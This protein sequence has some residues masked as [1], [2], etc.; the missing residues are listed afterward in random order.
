MSS[1][2]KFY[3]PYKYTDHQEGACK[4]F[5]PAGP[6]CFLSLVHFSTTFVT[7]TTHAKEISHHRHQNDKQQS[8]ESTHND[9]N[10]VGDYL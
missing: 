10:L 2:P 6:T 5:P 9:T 1:C 4:E 8:Q 3:L 7:A